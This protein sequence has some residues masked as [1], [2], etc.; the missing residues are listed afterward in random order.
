[1]SWKSF[2]GGITSASVPRPINSGGG[3]LTQV[4]DRVIELPGAI[5]DVGWVVQSAWM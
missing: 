1:M 3:R 4:H 2:F 5:F